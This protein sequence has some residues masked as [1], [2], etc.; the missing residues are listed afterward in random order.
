MLQ[1]GL[2]GGYG[3]SLLQTL[4]ALAAVCILAWV[5]LRWS[6]KRGLNLG[7]G[8]IKVLERTRLDGRRALYLVEVGDRVLLVGAGEGG[9]PAL[10]AEFDPAELPPAPEGPSSVADL[11]ARWRARDSSG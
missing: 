10:L 7:T 4:L 3:V 6:A 8:R 11:V 9:A 1:S 5:V 2:P